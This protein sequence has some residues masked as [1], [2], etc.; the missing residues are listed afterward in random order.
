MAK[1]AETPKTQANWMQVDGLK[2]WY[3]IAHHYQ[4]AVYIE[5]IFFFFRL[6]M[7]SMPCT[8]SNQVQV[9]YHIH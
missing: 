9:Q 2:I 7:H 1:P 3:G 6:R 5:Q 8:M 4:H